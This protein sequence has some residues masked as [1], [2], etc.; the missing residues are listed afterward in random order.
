[1]EIYHPKD[2]ELLREMRRVRREKKRKRILWGLLVTLV[3][4]A[5][6]GWL[7]LNR[8]FMLAEMR[9][10]AMGDALPEGTLVMVQRT[11]A[12]DL[13]RG[14]LI[15]YETEDGYQIKRIIALGGDNIVQNP[16]T[17]VRVNGAEEDHSR[18]IGRHS[19]AGVTT[20]RFSVPDG[21]FFVQGDMVS[22]SVDS[23]D[24]N[25]GTVSGDKIIGKAVFVLWPIS[26]IGALPTGTTADGAVPGAEVGE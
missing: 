19:D 9:G 12:N 4:C 22:I 20:R 17:G 14:D 16:Y 21:E 24:R 10:P 26:R 13:N 25:Y 6:F 2:D 5:L 18:L 15:L 23:R 1:M 7:V 11:G 3:L 8:M